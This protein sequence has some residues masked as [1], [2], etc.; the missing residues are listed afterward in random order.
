MSSVATMQSIGW[1]LTDLRFI[2]L[3]TAGTGSVKSVIAACSPAMLV[4]DCAFWW[5]CLLLLVGFDGLHMGGFLF[6]P[7]HI[8]QHA[9]SF[10]ACVTQI[11]VLFF[12]ALA[13]YQCYFLPSTQWFI[14]KL[15]CTF[16]FQLKANQFPC[17]D[18]CLCAPQLHHIHHSPG[19]LPKFYAATL[20]VDISGRGWRGGKKGGKGMCVR[21]KK[22][23]K[24]TRKSSSQFSSQLRGL[25]TLLMSLRIARGE[26]RLRLW[27]S[28][29]AYQVFLSHVAGKQK[30]F[31][32]N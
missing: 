7:K 17:F 32:S 14:S 30:T 15:H 12:C 21:K 26:K 25:I 10:W 24:E 8:C 18:L 19:S 9:S 3:W 28:S 27:L 4:S 6:T 5:W 22:K 11:K 29:C 13:C 2:C 31:Q 1:A 23:E 16:F 20:R